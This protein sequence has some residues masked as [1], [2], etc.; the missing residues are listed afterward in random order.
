MSANKK[1]VSKNKY[2]PNL[3]WSNKAAIIILLLVSREPLI[4]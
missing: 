2:L 4:F 1:I 3:S